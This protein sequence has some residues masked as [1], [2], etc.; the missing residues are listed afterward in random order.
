[1]KL[2]KGEKESKSICDSH[3]AYSVPYL[4]NTVKIDPT[5][6]EHLLSAGRKLH[7]L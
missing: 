3:P 6:D 7:S 4:K 2:R 5:E 1:M